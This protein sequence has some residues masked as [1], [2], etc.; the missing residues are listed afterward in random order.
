MNSSLGHTN[1]LP[2]SSV[3]LLHIPEEN[4]RVATEEP[5]E[6]S[7]NHLLMKPR[8]HILR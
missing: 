7:V 2:L 1:L 5:V 4:G 8:R 6:I 3:A